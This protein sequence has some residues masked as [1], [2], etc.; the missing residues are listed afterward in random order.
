MRIVD[1][2]KHRV[3]RFADSLGARLLRPDGTVLSIACVLPPP[4]DFASSVVASFVAGATATQAGTT[5]TVSAAPHGIPASKNGCKI[6]YP[7]SPSIP[8]GWY[9][10]LTWVDVNTIRFQRDAAAT[11]SS[12]S[13]NAG[14]ALTG[15]FVKAASVTIPGGA[16]GNNGR[17]KVNLI[18][19]GDTAAGIKSVR[20]LIAGVYAC[21]TTGTTFPCG[22]A[23]MTIWNR[24]SS[25]SQITV[26]SNDGNTGS[27]FQQ[28]SIDTGADFVVDLALSVT[29]PS[30]WVALDAFDVE[31]VRS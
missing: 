28:L 5:V 16:L 11:V 30:Q 18:R 2:F 1:I 25:S 12:E 24:N 26:A 9:T 4:A 20:L 6:Y 14:A 27:S 22:T 15:V 13:V 31:I 3:A 29:N 17:V 21:L 19:T 10:G 7:G 23:S 8:S